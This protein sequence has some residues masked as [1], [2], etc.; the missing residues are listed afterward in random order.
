L[1]SI[2]RE[3]EKIESRTDAG[4]IELFDGKKS[5]QDIHKI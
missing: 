2:E 5:E 1:H 4:E 3:L